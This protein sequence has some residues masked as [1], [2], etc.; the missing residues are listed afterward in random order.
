MG[1]DTP[2]LTMKGHQESG[3][4]R[5]HTYTVGDRLYLVKVTAHLDRADW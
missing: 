5:S 4:V 3:S 1:Q 2:G